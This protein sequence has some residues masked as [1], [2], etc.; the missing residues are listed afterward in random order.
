MMDKTHGNLAQKEKLL[1]EYMEVLYALHKIL[2][3]TQ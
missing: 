3:A 2:L 1:K